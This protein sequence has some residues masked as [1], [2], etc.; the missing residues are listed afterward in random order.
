MYFIIVGG[1]ITGTYQF[2]TG[3]HGPGD[4][5]DEFEK[6][7]YS[8]LKKNPFK[9]CYLDGI[10]IASKGFFLQPKNTVDKFSSI[11][12]YSNIDIDWLICKRFQKQ[13]EYSDLS[14]RIWNFPADR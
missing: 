2:L 1:N 9:I 11:L 7:R 6:I 4:M 3:F 10:L 13:L 5:L 12:D 14:L 8:E